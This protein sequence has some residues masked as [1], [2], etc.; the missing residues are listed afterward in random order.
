MKRTEE[1]LEY[2]RTMILQPEQELRVL[3]VEDSTL[4][5]ELVQRELKRANF[6]FRALRVQTKEFYLQALFEFSP[7]VILA[8]YTLPQF[9]GLEALHVL[10][11]LAL[12]IPFI[13]VTGSQSEEVAVD[14]MKEGASDYILKQS[15][16]RLPSAILSAFEKKEAE[17]NKRKAEQTLRESERRFHLLFD[18]A[19]LPIWVYDL[20]SLKFL[21][22]NQAAVNRYGFS[23]SEFLRMTI[24]EIQEMGEFLPTQTQSSHY[25]RHTRKDGTRIDVQ[26][27]THIVEFLGRRSLLMI[28]EDITERKKAE[29]LLRAS[30]EQLRQLSAHLQSVREEE[31]TRIAREIHDEL[32][33]SLTALK[34]DASLIEKKIYQLNSPELQSILEK[35]KQM[36]GLIDATL[37]FVRKL[38]VELRPGI[39]DDLGLEAAIEWQANEFQNRTGIRCEYQGQTRKRSIPPD[40]ATAVFRI[41]QET[42]TNI[43]RH[44]E[45]T[46]VWV[47]LEITHNQL[48]L[49]VQ[50]NGKGIAEQDMSKPLSLGILGMKERA[51]LLGGELLFSGSFGSGTKVTLTVPLQDEKR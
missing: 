6:V 13:L 24:A 34:I 32:G 25:A 3:L 2:R 49:E 36:N 48:V 40:H 26:V 47:S 37:I 27:V 8:D 20:D 4:D 21:E 15:L 33:Q 7:D 14:C 11:E 16:I 31:R 51:L 18:S 10:K 50:D 38:A 23:R 17:R 44:A 30:R 19:P 43:T 29:E 9:S 42:L 22:V 28:S 35:I 46:R 39:L 1:S 45:A 12:D 41:F 5:A